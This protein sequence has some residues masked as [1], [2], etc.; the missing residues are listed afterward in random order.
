MSRRLL[1]GTVAVVVLGALLG[2][3]SESTKPKSLTLAAREFRAARGWYRRRSIEAA[4]L[5]ASGNKSKA[6]ADLGIS[7]FALQRKLD[8]YGLESRKGAHRDEG[9]PSSE[10]AD[11]SS[12]RSAGE[13]SPRIEEPLDEPPRARTGKAAGNAFG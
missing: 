2:A 6:A 1:A 12:R 9:D 8:K 4:L 3:C 7:R 11:D 10:P 13:R 5:G